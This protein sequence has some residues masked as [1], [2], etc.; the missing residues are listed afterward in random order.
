[1]ENCL[2]QVEAFEFLFECDM[3]EL[4]FFRGYP[5]KN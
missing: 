3:K 2:K 5:E 4:V 1:V